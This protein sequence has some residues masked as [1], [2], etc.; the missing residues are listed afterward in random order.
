MVKIGKKY[1]DTGAEE[2]ILNLLLLMGSDSILIF[3]QFT[4]KKKV[5]RQRK[6]LDNI[7]AMFDRRF[8]LV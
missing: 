7:I 4:I 8:E 1:N 6:T 5:E 2:Q 3:N